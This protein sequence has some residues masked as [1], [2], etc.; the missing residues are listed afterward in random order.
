[1]SFWESKDIK[2]TR[3]QHT[4]EY[5]GTKILIGSSC[6]NEV[7]L[8]EGDFN[9]YYLC[10]RCVL[11]MDMFRDRDNDELGCLHDEVMD[12]DLLDCPKCKGWNKSEYDWS[13]DMQSMSLECDNCGHKWMVDLSLEALEKLQANMKQEASR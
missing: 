5:C 11:F 1:M 6:R 3:K 10:L 13:D 4:C 8:Y 7:G 2:K 12:N 9:H